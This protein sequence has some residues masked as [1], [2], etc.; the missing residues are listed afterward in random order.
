MRPLGGP[1]RAHLRGLL[2]R[3]ERLSENRTKAAQTG[4]LAAEWLDEASTAVRRT[5]AAIEQLE[6]SVAPL[7][8]VAL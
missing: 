6:A 7:P 8:S 1:L 3:I 4:V 5:M 2:G